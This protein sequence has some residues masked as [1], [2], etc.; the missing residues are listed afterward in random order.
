MT[1]RVVTALSMALPAVLAQSAGT[2]R[3]TGVTHTTGVAELLRVF[4]QEL[5]HLFVEA[6]HARTKVLDLGL[7]YFKVLDQVLTLVR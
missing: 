7:L 6:E 2:A 5:L 4:G 1:A 3:P